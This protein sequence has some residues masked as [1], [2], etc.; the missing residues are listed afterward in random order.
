MEKPALRNMAQAAALL[1][2][3]QFI[4]SL[5]YPFSNEIQSQSAGRMQNP[6]PFEG[7]TGEKGAISDDPRRIDWSRDSSPPRR[8][9][10]VAQ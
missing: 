1:K 2:M 3:N 6:P 10:A 9:G 4:G 7:T 8:S 5:T